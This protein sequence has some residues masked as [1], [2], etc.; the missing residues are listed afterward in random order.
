MSK[1][2]N[3]ITNEFIFV[4]QFYSFT[5]L[6][7]LTSFFP[8]HSTKILFVTLILLLITSLVINEFEVPKT[9]INITILM[10]ILLLIEVFFRYNNQT[11][12]YKRDFFIYGIS[13][14]CFVSQV[15]D[16]KKY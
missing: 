14:L 6:K 4:F 3:R 11:I 12:N 15:K 8:K 10:S 5:L 7:P 2:K 1:G 16:V 9:F 13:T